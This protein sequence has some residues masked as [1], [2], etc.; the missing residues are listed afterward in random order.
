MNKKALIIGLIIAFPIGL[1]FF[2]QFFSEGRYDIPLYYETGVR[3]DTLT[4]TTCI[5]RTA[6]QY[7]V[8]NDLLPDN[9]HRI[10][11]FERFDGPVLKTRLEELERVQDAHSMEEK[12]EM[13]SFVNGSTM[14]ANEV[15]DYGRRVVFLESFWK[16]AE[17]DS[18]TWADL[19]FCDLVMDKL[20]NRIVLVDSKNRIRGYYNIMEREETDRLISELGV[21]LTNK[22]L[23]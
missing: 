20:D 4:S 14:K 7:Y 23:Q 2:F 11:H 13:L 3:P 21:L 1:I 15:T 10:I 9:K 6:E 17:L 12:V 18:T 8:D 16:I 19:K 22:E 5:P